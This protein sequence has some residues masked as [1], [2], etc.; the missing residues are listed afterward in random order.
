MSSSQYKREPQFIDIESS[1]YDEDSFP[2]CIAWSLPD[3]QIKNVLIM[4]DDDWNPQDCPLPEETLQHLYD[5][6]VSGIDIIRELNSDLDGKPAYVDGVDYDE[7]LLNKLYETFDE[8]PTFELTPMT[9]LF[10]H[11]DL[12]SI[13]DSKKSIIQENDLDTQHAEQNVL[14]LLILARDNGLI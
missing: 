3:G 14:S 1:S 8:E 12:E 10:T 7:D 4:P 6:G 9:S 5:H 11:Q 2:T 13:M